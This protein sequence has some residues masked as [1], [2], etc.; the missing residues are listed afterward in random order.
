MFDR[1]LIQNFDWILL[2]LLFLIGVMSVMNLYS[3]TFPIRHEGGSTIFLKQIYWFLIGFVV[4]LAMEI[5][6]VTP[7]FGLLLFVM[8]G[9]S[10]KGT[11]LQEVARAA[12]PYIACVFLLVALVIAFPILATFIPSMM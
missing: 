7:P 11:T 12:L 9:V 1:R 3:A 6:L 2:L 8:H 5:S 4:L 10:P